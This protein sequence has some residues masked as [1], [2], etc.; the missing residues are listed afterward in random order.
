[1]SQKT[2]F[3]RFG[4]SSTDLPPGMQVCYNDRMEP[5]VQ[6]FLPL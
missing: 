2:L 5:S 6:E 3:V 1:M 4:H